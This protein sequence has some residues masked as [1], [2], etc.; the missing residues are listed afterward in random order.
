MKF[1]D[2]QI[3]EAREY[4][5][6]QLLGFRGGRRQKINCPFHKERT[7]SLVIYRDGSF[8]CFGCAKHGSNAIDFLVEMG[9]SFTQAVEFLLKNK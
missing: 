1:T 7:P 2:T 4:G 9:Q 3:Q 5:V 8:Y 6:H